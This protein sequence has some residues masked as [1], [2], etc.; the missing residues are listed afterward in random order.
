M[1]QIL[2]GL[3]AP[4]QQS[5]GAALTPELPPSCIAIDRLMN[6]DEYKHLQLSLSNHSCIH[7]PRFEISH[8]HASA[9]CCR[10]IA[11]D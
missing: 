1:E 8:M 10:W 4:F 2:S 9:C 11:N 6:T 5:V 3:Q 7:E